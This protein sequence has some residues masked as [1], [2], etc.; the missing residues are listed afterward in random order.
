MK[1]KNFKEYVYKD[2]S[3][4]LAAKIVAY[5]LRDNI[6]EL[7]KVNIKWNM[8]YVNALIALI[9]DAIKNMNVYTIE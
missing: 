3:M 8:A 9:E 5:N 1:K 2:I 4:L 7:S 6:S